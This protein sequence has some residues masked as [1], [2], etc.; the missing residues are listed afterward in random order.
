MSRSSKN[1]S[2]VVYAAVSLA[3]A[4]SLP[5]ICRLINPSLGK[6]LSPMHFP[7]LL[8]GFAAGPLC[9]AAVGILSPL[10]NGLLFGSPAVYPDMIRMMAELC[11][12]GFFAGFF[13]RYLPKKFPGIM[14]SLVAAML[15][16][17]LFWALSFYVISLVDP[18]TP[19]YLEYIITKTVSGALLGIACQVILIPPTVISLQKA[20]LILVQ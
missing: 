15:F 16:G 6:L 13:Y 14:C 17:R 18:K 20:K 2:R 12:Y 10:C 3:L 7:V 1:I 8:C 19:F 4:I 9:G 5:L 11:A